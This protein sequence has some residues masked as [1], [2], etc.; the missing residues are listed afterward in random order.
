MPQCF[1][2]N[3]RGT[4]GEIQ[5]P[6]IGIEH[7]DSEPVIAVLFQERLGEA[8]G[9]AAEDEVIVGAVLGVGVEFGAVG[10]DEPEAGVGG[11]ALREVG[12]IFPAVPGELLPVIHAGAFELGIVQFE[13]EGFDEV[14]DGLGG[15][16]EAGDVAG[17]GGDFG[18]EEDEVHGG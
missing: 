18:F 1:E 6:G 17:V 12:P 3:E 13:A 9:F 16:A 10:F 7:G 11:E 2:E 8:G 14:E 4:V 15:G 5:G